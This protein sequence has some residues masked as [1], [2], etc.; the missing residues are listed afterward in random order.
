MTW[1]YN[2]TPELDAQ[3]TYKT[4]LVVCIVVPAIMAMMVGLRVYTRVCV[5]CRMGA[6]DW[7]TIAAVGRFSQPRRPS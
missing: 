2:G 4:G 7:L 1:T 3:S 5:V 6:D